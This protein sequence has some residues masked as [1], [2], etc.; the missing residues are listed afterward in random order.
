MLPN[1]NDFVKFDDYI[2]NIISKAITLQFLFKKRFEVNEK[3]IFL[4]KK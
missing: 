4:M 3:K 2:G 1:F